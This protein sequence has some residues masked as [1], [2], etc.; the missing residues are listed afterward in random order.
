MVG[1]TGHGGGDD[2]EVEWV[3]KG[4]RFMVD[5]HEGNEAVTILGPDF[6]HVA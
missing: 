6:G 4:E 2:L 1:A 3:P 5:E